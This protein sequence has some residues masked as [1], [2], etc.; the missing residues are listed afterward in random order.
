M[1]KSYA[2]HLTETLGGEW[3]YDPTSYS[4]VDA[5]NTKRYVCRV[6]GVD[7]HGEI[8][9]PMGRWLYGDGPPRRLDSEPLTVSTK[10]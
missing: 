6:A 2:R 1:A 4:W 3:H 5:R 10:S 7:E 8:S 9:I